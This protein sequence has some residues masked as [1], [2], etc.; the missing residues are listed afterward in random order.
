MFGISVVIITIVCVRGICTG[1]FQGALYYCVCVVIITTSHATSRF[2]F[3]A[4][5]A[6]QIGIGIK[7]IA[8]SYLPDV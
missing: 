2:N 7:I 6:T 1:V 3:G 4:Y 8:Q 5:G